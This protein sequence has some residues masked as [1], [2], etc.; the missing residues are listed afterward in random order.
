M[1]KRIVFV[2]NNLQYADGVAKVLVELCNFLD[3]KL[4]DITIIPI[5]RCDS[6]FIKLLKPHIHIQK[7]L[8]FYFRGLDKIVNALPI[9][10]LYQK[11]VGGNY[12]IEVA[13]QY[14]LATRMIANSTNHNAKHYA[15]MHGY[16]EGLTLGK[17]Y[18]KFDKVFCVSKFNEERLRR[19]SN[20]TVNVDCCYNIIDESKIL[21]ASKDEISE[22]TSQKPIFVAVGRQTPEKGFLRLVDVVSRLKK[23]GYHFTL[24]LIGDGAE[25]QQ[26]V[27]KVSGEKLEDTV[28]LLG[29]QSNP[30]KFTAKADVFICSSFSEGYSTACAESILLGVPVISTAVSGA[31]EI[32]DDSQCG[33]VCQLDDASLYDALKHVLDNPEVISTWKKSLE[34]TKLKFGAAARG[35]RAS[36]IFRDNK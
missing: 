28:K 8:G 18:P 36:S 22:D 29:I 13:F 23:D 26:L 3:E 31:Q 24:W 7:I 17:E 32:I 6:N 27:D 4:F 15:W 34:T 20:G 12:D 35:E 30:H 33:M 10:F 5:Y 2:L 9:R 1:K 19:E 25:H 11:I 14:G 16:D 21:E